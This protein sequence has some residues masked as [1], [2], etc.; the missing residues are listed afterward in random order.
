M[1]PGHK[2]VISIS[3]GFAM[4]KKFTL[5]ILM[6][7]NLAIYSQVI[8][9]DEILLD[10]AN[11]PELETLQTPFCCNVFIRFVAPGQKM[12]AYF[13]VDGQTKFLN[14][15]NGTTFICSCGNPLWPLI[16]NWTFY[17]I[18]ELRDVELQVLQCQQ[19]APPPPPNGTCDWVELPVDFRVD[20]QNQYKQKIYVDVN[21]P[22]I[23]PSW[24][25]SGYITFNAATPSGNCP[26]A[27]GNYCDNSSWVQ[28]PEVEL[29]PYPNSNIISTYCSTHPKTM[30]AFSPAYDYQT[31]LRSLNASNVIACYNQIGQTWQFNLDQD[32][33]IY[34]QIGICSIN[35]ANKNLTYID[36]ESDININKIPSEKCSI[37]LR[38]FKAHK[39]Y[40]YDIPTQTYGL[41]IPDGGYLIKEVILEH[42]NQHKALYEKFMNDYLFWWETKINT[43]R[44]ICST[45]TNIFEAR[46]G[47][48]N[49]YWDAFFGKTDFTEYFYNKF[50][51]EWNKF[52]GLN[53]ENKL[54]KKRNEQ[55]TNNT[56]EVQELIDKYIEKLK[57]HCG[58]N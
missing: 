15:I 45:Y 23:P 42:E 29:V 53:P 31:N 50:N 12:R 14:E 1:C 28:I 33:K 2:C 55:R 27:C 49:M 54:R 9:K 6:V 36:S 38:S 46:K 39:E 13:T 18:P 57:A 24:R 51:S 44:A 40:K 4:F 17:E 3:K 32:V 16:G 25:Y 56:K 8:I 11:N 26:N 21:Y 58:I 47:G 41:E 5:L 43:F 19:V 48:F 52:T 35:V 30:A 34:Y 7:F 10:E 37:A 22:H 20:P